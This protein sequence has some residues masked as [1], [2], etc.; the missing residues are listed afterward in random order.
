MPSSQTYYTIK[1]STHMSKQVYKYKEPNL[2]NTLT[3]NTKDFQ[4]LDNNHNIVK[5]QCHIS[6]KT[7]IMV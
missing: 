4:V 1:V 6:F 7:S 2:Q 3:L 5:K